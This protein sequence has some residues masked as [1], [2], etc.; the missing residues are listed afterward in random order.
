[1]LKKLNTP[2]NKNESENNQK[3]GIRQNNK[4]NKGDENNTNNYDITNNETT[5][6]VRND[7]TKEFIKNYRQSDSENVFLSGSFDVKSKVNL[8]FCAT[9]GEYSKPTNRLILD[10]ESFVKKANTRFE[11]DKI[12]EC[13]TCKETFHK[14]A[15]LGGHMSKVHPKTSKKFEERM[16]IYAMRKSERDKRKFLNNL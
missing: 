5:E 7:V 12:Y 11:S 9:E 8:R 10:F 2:I 6:S 13:E 15:A 1:M 3:V 14:H 4:L 16:H